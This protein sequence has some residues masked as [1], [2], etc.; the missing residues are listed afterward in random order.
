M[1]LSC[2][3]GTFAIGHCAQ[4][5]RPV[6]GIHS[7]MRW[8]RRLCREH[9]QAHETAAA[10]AKAAAEQEAADR[11]ARQEAL[12]A[13]VEAK[14]W[15]QEEAKRQARVAELKALIPRAVETLKTIR[16]PTSKL[17]IIEL[18]QKVTDFPGMGDPMVTRNLW[19]KREVGP[20]WLIASGPEVLYLTSA[21]EIWLGESR[22]RRI[23]KCKT[24][25]VFKE[26]REGVSRLLAEEKWFTSTDLTCFQ[27]ELRRLVNH[28]GG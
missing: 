17:A 22:S 4:C 10:Q 15:Q 7:G 24:G 5:N 13:T 18:R 26:T 8:D 16:R 20:G 2:D 11:A 12:T 1:S 9:I 25:G 28:G 21:G 27:D 6:C 23:D 19:V 14:R 3:C